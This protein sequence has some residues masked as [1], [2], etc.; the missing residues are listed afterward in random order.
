MKRVKVVVFGLFPTTFSTCAPCCPS[1]IL[2][3]CS[4]EL[5]QIDEY[6][7]SIRRNQDFLIDILYRLMRFGDRVI[8]HIVGADSIGGILLSIRHRLGMGPAIIVGGRVF[9]GRDLDIDE[10]V[11]Y[12]GSL[13]GGV[14]GSSLVVEG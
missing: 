4:S 6:P 7:L 12:I 9:K 3:G 13:L 8:V 5:D 2:Y 11:E 14:S 10:V 1:D